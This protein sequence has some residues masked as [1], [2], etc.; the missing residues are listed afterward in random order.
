MSEGMIAFEPREELGK[1]AARRMRRAGRVPAVIYGE[2]EK[3]KQ[4]S[5]DS[6]ELMLALKQDHAILNLAKDS[7][8][9]RVIVREIQRH[10][11][12]GTIIHVDFLQVKKGQKLTLSVP[13]KFEGRPLGVQEG[14]ML[15]EVRNEVEIEVLP[16]D[17]P[18]FIEINIDNLEIGDSI[19][20]KDIEA[21]NFTILTDE[22]SVLCRCEVPRGLVEEEAVEG[23][24]EEEL[25]EEM[26]EPEVITAKDK[27]EEAGE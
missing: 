12:K 14:G 5:L 24:E 27:D 10:P 4:V 15:D 11:V 8:K 19:R 17:I 25:D 1:A 21:E 9:H 2:I 26:A 13:L 3:S 20:V 6:H 16:K 18:N 23:E 22:D 7:E